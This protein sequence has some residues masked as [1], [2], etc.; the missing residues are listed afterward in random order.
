MLLIQ[1]V[2][3]FVVFGV[4]LWATNTRI[5]IKGTIKK[6]LNAVIIVVAILFALSAFGFMDFLSGLQ[7]GR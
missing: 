4:I 5:P 2:I 3:I 6:I 1:L 7:V